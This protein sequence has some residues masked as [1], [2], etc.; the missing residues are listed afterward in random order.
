[1]SEKQKSLNDFV[2]LYPISKTLRFELIPQGE[3]LNN[4]QKNN[5]ISTDKLRAESYKEMKKTL[6]EY[7]RWFIENTLK[8]AKL[9]KLNEYFELYCSSADTKKTED[10]KNKFNKIKSDLRKEIVNCFKTGDA[11]DVF[12]KLD[13]KELIKDELENWITNQGKDIYFDEG[14]KNFTTYFSGYHIN[15]KNMYSEDEKSTAIAYRLINENLPKFIDNIKIFEKVSETEIGKEFK[16]LYKDL[17]VYLNV[18]NINELFTIENYNDTLT[19]SQIE[20]YNAVI[21]GKTEE[22]GTK[23][24]GLNEYINLYN[25]KQSNKNA[26]LPKLKQLYKQILSPSLNISFLPEAF[27][28]TQELLKAT[29]EFYNKNLLSNERVSSSETMNILEE[30]KKVLFN[31]KDYELEKVYLRNDTNMTTISQKI[32]G[33]YNFI[34]ESLS[35]YYDIFINPNYQKQYEKTSDKEKK[36]KEKERFTKQNYLSI[37]ILQDAVNTYINK[38]D[39]S[40]DNKLIHQGFTT[41]CIADYFKNNFFSENFES[42]KKFDFI[43]NIN[44]KYSCVKGLLNND[45]KEKELIQQ[46]KDNLKVFLDS[47]LEMLHFVKPLYLKNSGEYNIDDVFYSNFIPLFEQFNEF[48]QLYDKIRNFVTKKPYNIEKFKLNFN[49]SS[50]LTGWAQKYETNGGIIFEKDGIYYVGIIKKSLSNEDISLLEKGSLKDAYRIFYDFQKPDNKNIPRLFIR[51]KGDNYAPAVEKYNLKIEDIIDIY[52]SGKFKTEYKK[53]NPVEYKAS[54]TKMID[55]FKTGFL[56]HESYKHY[57]FAWKESLEYNDISEFYFDCETA[58]YQLKKIPIN[59]NVL[60]ELVSQDKIYLFQIYN[61]DFSRYSKG[62]PNLH[63]LYWKALFDEENIKNVIY[64]LNG[65]AEIFYREKSVE[66]SKDKMEMGHHYEELKNKFAY[67]IIKDKRYTSDKFMLHVPITLN[68]KSRQTPYINKN[69]LGFLKNN[70]SVNI[71]GI[72][73]GERNLLYLSLI[74]QKGNVILNEKDEPIQ[75]SLNEIVN[76]YYKDGEI[77]SKTVNYHNK[78]DAKEKERMKAR[79]NWGTIENIKELKEGYLSQ[80]VHLISKLMVEHN[81]IVVMEDL[82]FGFKRGRFK[83]EK[84]VYQK[85]EKMLID[86]LNYLVLKNK[87]DT[88]QGGLYKA[89][90]LTSK[91][92]SFE[93]LG[94]QCGFIFYVPAWNTSKIDPVTGFVDF[95]HPKHNNIKE[96]QEFFAKF[97]KI[98]FNKEKDYFEF[99]FD[100]N[101]FTSQAEGTKTYWTIC[102]HGSERYAFNK[103]LNNNKGSYEKWNV[104]EKIKELLQEYKISYETGKDIKD[105]ISKILDAKFLI[106]MMKCLNVLL[107][108]RYS[109]AEDEKDFILSPVANEEGIFFNS[110]NAEETMPKDADANGAYHIAKKGLWILKEINKSEDLNKINL[111]ISNK[112]WLD[113]VQNKRYLEN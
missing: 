22:D 63:T 20:A 84:Q 19:Q 48:T 73:R 76:K 27:K 110:E 107:A 109:Y 10:F 41:T 40:E 100:Y 43:S 79:E 28:N 83:V 112:E 65:Q 90:Q 101:N 33:N 69:V 68:F 26:R 97:D 18:N 47:I 66:Y 62:N 8:N 102:S 103:T 82:N 17:E 91:F 53:K 56:A 31:L 3:T 15:R 5:L 14:F 78:L 96:S 57:N 29:N 24:K 6:D 45:F 111:S 34:S 105:E 13:K 42:G 32:F 88:E 30:I 113:F 54:L 36:Q 81:A 94:K 11:K 4:I 55:Y 51:S 75:Y 25:Q 106:R 39:D 89:L 9:T 95:L 21:G 38:K 92:E 108:L 16:S 74:N 50:L 2:G 70:P 60:N 99:S 80:V 49:C 93:K 61:K 46:Q 72:D 104:T 77:V 71:I 59:F 86:K 37:K 44:A 98:N 23:I 52:D 87:K 35:E 67:P 58:C 12:D 64:K 7:H 85:F 1:M